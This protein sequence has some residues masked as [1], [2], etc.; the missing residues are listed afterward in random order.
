[1][2][3]VDFRTIAYRDKNLFAY[4]NVL[5]GVDLKR[6][7]SKIEAQKTFGDSLIVAN[8]L[9]DLKETEE[10]AKSIAT[11]VSQLNWRSKILTNNQAEI[12]AIKKSLQTVK[13]FHYA[14]HV[15]SSPDYLSQYQ[16]PLAKNVSL[17]STDILMLNRV[18]KWVVLSACNSSKSDHQVSAESLGLAHAFIISGSEQVIATTQ[19][20][21]D[22]Q[23]SLLMTQFY[24]R[25]SSDENFSSAFRLAQLDLIKHQPE[26]DWLAFRVITL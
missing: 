9:G 17:N 4:K 21:T 14:G 10:E 19:P 16:I 25:W 7:K 22:K 8:S 20:V 15:F 3:D 13:H 5:Y 23:A 26:H 18:P 12:G 11:A 6:L 1:M 2:K 24:Q